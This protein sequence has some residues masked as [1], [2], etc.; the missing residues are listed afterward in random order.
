MPERTPPVVERAAEKRVGWAELFFDLVFVVAVTRVSAVIEE[1]HSG[2]GL[3]RALVV[4]APAYWLWVGTSVQANLRDTERPWFRVQ[5]FGI[6]L[7]AVFMALAV[8]EAYRHLGLLYGVAYWFGRIVLGAGMV[9]DGVR[10]R[11]W[12]V[13]PYLVSMVLTGPMLIVGGLLDGRARLILWA[14]AAVTDLSTPT[15]LRRWLQSMHYDAGHLTERFGL[16]VLIAIGESVVAAGTSADAAHLS[17]A[18]GFAVAAAFLLDCGLWWVYFHFAA[19]AMRHSLATAR[20]QLD[21]TRL[22]LSYGHLAFI[23]GIVLISVGLRS[24]VHAPGE[25]LDPAVAGLLYGGC[26]LFLAAFGFTRWAMFRLVSWTRL[27]AAAVVVVALPVA[28]PA[29][30]LTSLVVLGSILAVLNVVEMVRVGRLR[31][32]HVM[33]SG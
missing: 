21:I 3:L 31:P 28:L 6:A 33:L 16:F 4:F 19:D 15:L 1:D 14:V 8:P 11:R 26:A 29:P 22:V 17:V 7:A 9:L 27:S 30:A 23:A 25:R 24:S 10:A 5:L 32:R 12:P 13:N 20:V 2:E 18:Q